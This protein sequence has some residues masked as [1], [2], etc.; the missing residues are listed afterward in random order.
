MSNEKSSSMAAEETLPIDLERC[1][2]T[3]E[4]GGSG[5]KGGAF[6]RRKDTGSGC[7]L[8]RHHLLPKPSVTG[9]MQHVGR[10]VWI[11]KYL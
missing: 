11:T 8:H 5:E 4:L 2:K 10:S 1:G 7:L 6:F 3:A 9:K